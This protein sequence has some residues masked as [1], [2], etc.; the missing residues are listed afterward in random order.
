MN[1]KQ[2]LGIRLV[3]AIV[4]STKIDEA[5]KLIAL[6]DLNQ[7]YRDKEYFYRCIASLPI[8]DTVCAHHYWGWSILGWK[9][10]SQIDEIIGTV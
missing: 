5:T 1:T 3:D 2:P 6:E 4:A 8:G 9:F 7:M 10:W